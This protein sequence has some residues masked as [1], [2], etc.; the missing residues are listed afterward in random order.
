MQIA[1]MRHEAAM[2]L[3]AARTERGERRE[4]MLEE[5]RLWVMLAQSGYDTPEETVPDNTV[6]RIRTRGGALT[7]VIGQKESGQDVFPWRCLGCRQGRD[8]GGAVRNAAREE[9]TR[10]ARDCWVLPERPA[11][12]P[13]DALAKTLADA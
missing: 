6:M 7:V 5:A 12:A 8:F 1:D 10:H 4:H 13:A 3:R 9:A 2:L 11:A